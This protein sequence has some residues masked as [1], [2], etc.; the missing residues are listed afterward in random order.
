[1]KKVIL[2]KQV[3]DEIMYLLYKAL[4][5]DEDDMDIYSPQSSSNENPSG[6]IIPSRKMGYL[7]TVEEARKSLENIFK[8][9]DTK[10]S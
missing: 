3:F 9:E 5:E 10:E 6:K 2:G 1:M 4:I 8:L 7:S